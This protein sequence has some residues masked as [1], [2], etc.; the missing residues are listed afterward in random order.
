MKLTYDKIKRRLTMQ[1]ENPAEA[2]ELKKMGEEMKRHKAGVN[3]TYP[4]GGTKL[5]L[6]P[7]TSTF[8]QAC[9]QFVTEQT[10]K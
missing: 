3:M 8:L 10:A 9:Q 7:A 1:S 2:T 6:T 5:V 4:G